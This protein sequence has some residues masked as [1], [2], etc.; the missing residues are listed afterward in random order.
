MFANK[1]GIHQAAVVCGIFYLLFFDY[2]HNRTAIYNTCAHNINL[3]TQDHVGLRIMK[4]PGT[5][6]ISL[7]VLGGLNSFHQRKLEDLAIAGT[8]L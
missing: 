5:T 1:A 4:S 6:S 7:D 3:T 2:I 8:N